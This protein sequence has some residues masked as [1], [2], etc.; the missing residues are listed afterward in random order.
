MANS[1]GDAIHATSPD[2]DTVVDDRGGSNSCAASIIVLDTTPPAITCPPNIVT[3]APVGAKNLAVNYPAPSVT[4]EI[5]T[6]LLESVGEFLDR[7]QPG[8]IL[9]LCRL[10][11]SPATPDG[12]AFLK[13]DREQVSSGDGDD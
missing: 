2:D 3:N 4:D 6:L 9:D 7:G 1:T 11:P 12:A 13:L 5:D 10:S 8:V